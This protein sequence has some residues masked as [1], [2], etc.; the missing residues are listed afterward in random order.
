MYSIPQPMSAFIAAPTSR[1]EICL[2]IMHWISA[3]DYFDRDDPRCQAE[4]SEN[5]LRPEAPDERSR[6]KRFAISPNFSTLTFL[7]KTA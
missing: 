6:A 1:T 7:V 2:A 3:P 4:E 5:A